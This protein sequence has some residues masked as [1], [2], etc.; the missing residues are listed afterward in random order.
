MSITKSDEI[1]EF[2]HDPD[3]FDVTQSEHTDLDEVPE[4]ATIDF[5]NGVERQTQLSFFI[6]RAMLD[7]DA[8]VV[9]N[10]R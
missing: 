10:A 7:P 1:A 6:Q 8:T 3:D 5:G 9:P 4:A 2:Y